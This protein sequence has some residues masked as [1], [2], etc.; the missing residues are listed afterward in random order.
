MVAARD[1]SLI[2]GLYG[3]TRARDVNLTSSALVAVDISSFCFVLWLWRHNLR[4]AL[5]KMLPRDEILHC[6]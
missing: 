6:S 2:D 1:M 5:D 4:L 3:T